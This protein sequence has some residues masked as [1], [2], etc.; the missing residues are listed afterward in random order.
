MCAYVVWNRKEGVRWSAYA[1]SPED[2]NVGLT[3]MLT[4]VVYYELI[5]LNIKWFSVKK[6]N[7]IV[8]NCL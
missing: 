8:C 5:K 7:K 4:C 1:I 2:V 6:N 3:I